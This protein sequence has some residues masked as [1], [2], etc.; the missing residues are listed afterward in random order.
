MTELSDQ[1]YS[2]PALEK[3]LDILEFLAGR[4]VPCSKSEIGDALERTP[5]EIYRMLCVLEERGYVQK[6]EGTAAYGLSMRL[7]ELGHQQASISTL[8]KAARIPME[9]LS[10]EISE[11]CHLGIQNGNNLLIMMERM[12]PRQVCLAVGEGTTFPLTQTVS[13]RVQLSLQDE[14]AVRSF[15]GEDSHFLSLSSNKQE[16]Y[17]KRIE[18]V[19]E[20]G[21]EIS[22]SEVSQG[23]VDI[24]VAV[25]IATTGLCASLAVSQLGNDVR[26]PKISQNLKAIQ[27]CAM[28]INQTL[29]VTQLS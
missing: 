8:R 18:M 15:L 3:G 11:A 21:F 26:A 19:R 23:V 2:A 22:Q 29:G 7:F 27:N 13:G 16:A 9:Q 12:P 5:S 14:E 20:R 4:N 28:R 25:G 24:A 6:Q 1:R 17:L 10:S